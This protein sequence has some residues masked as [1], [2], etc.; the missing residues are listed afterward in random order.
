MGSQR[1]EHLEIENDVKV[2]RSELDKWT[3]HRLGVQTCRAVE[4]FFAMPGVQEEYERWLEQEY[5]PTHNISPIS[6]SA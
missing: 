2:K 3:S 6:E 5:R 1:L 4:R